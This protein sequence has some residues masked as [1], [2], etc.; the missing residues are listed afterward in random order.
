MNLT[1]PRLATYNAFPGLGGSGGGTTARTGQVPTRRGRDPHILA[2]YMEFLTDAVQEGYDKGVLPEGTAR[3]ALESLADRDVVGASDEILAGIEV[4]HENQFNMAAGALTDTLASFAGPTAALLKQALNDPDAVVA[5]SRGALSKVNQ[6]SQQADNLLRMFGGS[7]EPE[8]EVS[9]DEESPRRARRRAKRSRDED[10]SIEQEEPERGVSGFVNACPECGEDAQLTCRCAIGE[11]SCM[12]GHKW[13]NCSAHDRRIS[14][15]FDAKTHGLGLNS[16]AGHCL[17]DIHERLQAASSPRRV[18]PPE[19]ALGRELARDQGARAQ[20][21]AG[22][23][24]GTQTGSLNGW[25]QRRTPVSYRDP[26]VLIDTDG[27]T[28]RLG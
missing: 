26:N 12:N 2:S 6:L 11:S 24:G 9:A 1:S 15:P 5:T 17:C 21:T 23:L 7:A 20:V 25:Q 28:A 19:R 4:A 14:I 18:V 22:A 27:L 10:E 8:P 13:V 16:R 3:R